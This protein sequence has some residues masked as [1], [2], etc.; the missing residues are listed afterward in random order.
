MEK[1]ELI[2]RRKKGFG[3]TWLLDDAVKGEKQEAT[4]LTQALEMW[5]NKTNIRCSFKLDPINGEIYS[6]VDDNSPEPTL[7][8]NI[9][10]DP[11]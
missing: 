1:L 11:S 7:R 3:D 6:I 4:S 8:Y 5:F 9:Y 10:G 2:A